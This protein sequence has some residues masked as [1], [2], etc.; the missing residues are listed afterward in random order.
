M[1]LLLASTVHSTIKEVMLVLCFERWVG[2]GGKLWKGRERRDVTCDLMKT[3]R[4]L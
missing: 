3:A 4:K 1:W 2:V